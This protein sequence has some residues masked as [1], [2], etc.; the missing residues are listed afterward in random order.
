MADLN[1]LATFM[2]RG[3][4]KLGA[5]ENY[6]NR[7]ASDIVAEIAQAVI[8]DFVTST[9][10]D[11]GLAV[12]NWQVTKDGPAVDVRPAFAPSPKGRRVKGVWVHAV[13]PEITRAANAPSVLLAASVVLQ[14]NAPGETIY[15]T[16]NTEYITELDSGSS[17]QS[18]GNFVE[19]AQIIAN[20]IVDKYK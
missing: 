17:L 10:T 4:P 20:G 8:E 1:D 18:P 14:Q 16:N 3:M 5:S 6:N 7:F 13:D 9:P 19:R 15:I 2:Y 12:S 11:T